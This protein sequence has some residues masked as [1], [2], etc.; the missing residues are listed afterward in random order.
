MRGVAQTISYEISLI[1]II[2]SFLILFKMLSFNELAHTLNF[3]TCAFPLLLGFWLIVTVAETNRTPFDFS[4]GERELV[5]GFNTEYRARKFALIF[6]TEY[7][8]IYLFSFLT[9]KL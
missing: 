6:I 7:A 2:T 8:A 3:E 5:S 1:F 4:E 9:Q